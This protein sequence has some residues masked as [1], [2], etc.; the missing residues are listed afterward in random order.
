MKSITVLVAGPCYG[1]LQPLDDPLARSR[2][3][4]SLGVN[5]MLLTVA[6]RFHVLT[7]RR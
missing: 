3:P 5:C 4:L 6:L 1:L 2:P 7:L